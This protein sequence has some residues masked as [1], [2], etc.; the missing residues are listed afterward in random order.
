MFI[1]SV[2]SPLYTL[3]SSATLEAGA[4]S[5]TLIKAISMTD[6]NNGTTGQNNSPNNKGE[7]PSYD[8]KGQV[9][10]LSCEDALCHDMQERG[11]VCDLDRQLS[12][13]I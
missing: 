10:M 13:D 4:V 5:L 12:H 11:Q 7:V 3:Y 8:Q 1:L 9:K 2:Y 6:Q